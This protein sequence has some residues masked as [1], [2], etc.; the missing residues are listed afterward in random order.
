M[1]LR[2]ALAA[3][4]LASLFFAG[5]T[6]RAQERSIPPIA[7]NMAAQD[8]SEPIEP[9][10]KIELFN[11]K[12]LDGLVGWMQQTGYEG[13]GKEYSAVDGT[14]RI[15]GG[16]N[17]YLRTAK[18]YKNYHV[19]VE[20]KWGTE[21]TNMSR[22]VRNSGL[23]LHGTGIDGG[24]SN[25]A[26]MPSIEIQLAQGCEGDII[27]IG[28]K[29]KDGEPIRA[30]ATG[31]MKNGGDNKPRWNPTEGTETKSSGKQ[32]WWSKHQEGFRELLDTRGEHDVASPYGEWTK[33]ECICWEDTITVKVNGETV[34]QVY[35]V[36]PASGY[37]LLEN[38]KYEVFFRNFELK[39][40]AEADRF[41]GKE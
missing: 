18:K 28:G 4:L 11:G 12:N 31:L 9:K 35:D 5:E 32:L 38:E 21:R 29:G 40:V 39:P 25:G 23:L 1:P 2:F 27:C 3:A 16:D 17:G 33:V 13:E 7:E 26:W 24:S 15:A 22:Y 37:I 36:Q 8:T 30:A 14:I 19:S 41:T 34:N 20:F 10:E 6:A